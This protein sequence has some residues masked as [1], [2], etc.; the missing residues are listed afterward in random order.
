MIHIKKTAK[1]KI[2]A[3]N[4]EKWTK[5]YLC[6]IASGKEPEKRLANAYN[7]PEVKMALKKETHGKCAYCESKIMHIDYG[8][9]EHILPKNKNAR[10]DICFE[11]SNLTLACSKCNR[12]GKGSY[13]NVN[14]PL[15]N[16]YSDYPEVHFRAL[17]SLVWPLPCDERAIITE[18]KLGL[19]RAELLERRQERIGYIRSLL[20]LWAKTESSNPNKA[21][22]E[23]AL[24]KEYTG[25]KEYSFIIKG[26]LAALDFPV[27]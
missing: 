2:L 12:S 17:G 16:P 8:D 24:H 7:H 23:E 9:I 6:C 1:P 27:K 19:N 22:I 13:Y 15:I 20:Q 10:P 14:F 18:G 3:D 21:I 4:A 5:E 26:F 11:W 25:K